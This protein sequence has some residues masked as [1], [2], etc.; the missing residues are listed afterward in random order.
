MSLYGDADR[1]IQRSGV[2][3]QSLRL[4]DAAALTTLTT[5]VLEQVSSQ[6][7]AYCDRDFDVHEVTETRNG[8]GRYTFRL[9]NYP[10]I[11]IDTLTADGVELV[12]GTDYVVSRAGIVERI[13]TTWREARR[14]I[15]ITYTY[16]YEIPPAAVVGIVEDAVANALGNVA[17][18]VAAKGASSM[19]MDGYSVAYSE[20][21]R[22]AMLAP[23]QLG[24]LDRYRR[25][26]GA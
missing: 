25:I 7:D 3:Y 8:T 5:T 24:I 15:E 13:G 20:L 23:E 11:E 1:T 19:S 22:V 6:V 10:V 2:T 18:N 21:S 26:G 4:A 9:L 17:R 14:N 12:E 16:G